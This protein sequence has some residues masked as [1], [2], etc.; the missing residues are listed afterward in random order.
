[1]NNRV[2]IIALVFSVYLI[3][4][5]GTKEFFTQAPKETKTKEERSSFTAKD[6]KPG[7]KQGKDSFISKAN[8]TKTKESF[9]NTTTSAIYKKAYLD[10]IDGVNLLNKYP[11]VRLLNHMV[12]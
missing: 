10:Y 5:K 7:V 11:E 1:M 2:F 3:S 4:C 12:V 8:E 9:Y 6:K